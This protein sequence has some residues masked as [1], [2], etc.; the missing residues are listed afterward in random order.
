MFSG[1]TE[2]LLRRVRRA[3]IAGQTVS[4]F[5]PVIDNRYSAEEVV[6][7]DRRSIR[8]QLVHRA[9]DILV[10]YSGE[11]V[12]G[13]DEAQFFDDGIVAVC[14]KLATKGVRVIV[15]GLDMDYRGEPFGAMPFLLAIADYVTKLQAVCVCCGGPAIHSYR[16]AGTPQDVVLVGSSD[17]YE[18]RCRRCF[19]LGEEASPIIERNTSSQS[20]AI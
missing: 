20:V 4:V 5:K 14:R 13:I 2:E 11:Q 12:V 18:P 3:L 6:S 8:S 9:E 16:R 17:I 7:H 1:K 19:L 10:C 15:S